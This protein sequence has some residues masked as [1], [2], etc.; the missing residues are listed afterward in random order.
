MNVRIS[1]NAPCPCGSGKKYKKCC[2]ANEAVSITS[3]LESEIDQLQRRMVEFALDYYNEEIED[4]FEEFQE[5]LMTDSQEELRFFEMVHSIWFTMF[6]PLE[7]GETILEKFILTAA[8][9]LKRPKLKQIL[10]SWIHPRVIIG[11]ITDTDENKVL[12]ED[13]F[14]LQEIEAIIPVMEKTFEK[15]TFII[16][17]LLPFDQQYAFIPAP[18]D[19]PS[20]E[21]EQAY[22]F[23]RKES[24]NAGYSSPQEYV[25]DFFMEVMYD[26]PTINGIVDVGEMDWPA[27]VYQEVAERFRKSLEA[28]GEEIPVIEIGI[29]LWYQFCQKKQKRIQNP[30]I[31]VGSLH[32]LITTIAPTKMNYTQK[33]IA[34]L[35]NASV[36]SISSIYGE[37]YDLLEDEIIKMID[38]EDSVI[39]PEQPSVVQFN[40]QKGPMGTERALQ[41]AMAELQGKNF[42]S[43]EEVNEFLNKKFLGSS[44]KKMPKGIKEQAMDLVYDAFEA[45]GSRRYQLAKEALGLDP[46][47]ADAY[48]ILAEKTKTLE[49]A[50]D[51]YEKAMKAAEEELGKSFIKE[52]KGHFWGLIETRP[53]MRAKFHYAQTLYRLGKMDD[54]VKQYQQL[55]DL[56]PND[57]QGVRESLFIA[58]M[59][60]GN[61]KSARELLEKYEE[62]TA[63]G[64]YNKVLLEIYEHGFTAQAEKLLAEAKKQNRYVIPF[65]REKKRIPKQ[66]PDYYGWGDE[67]EAVIYAAGHLELWKRI[68]GLEDWLK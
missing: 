1:R 62:E 35:Y 55:L 7:D 44:P 67:N 50:A 51:M 21:V 47:N 22:E 61:V 41:E 14:T 31:Y 12:A 68:E 19:L 63:Q 36:G 24:Q 66:L 58:Y 6:V 8:P 46:N 53:F 34:K 42:E 33:E 56:N 5:H 25:T 9:K 2:G 65:L 10:E 60:S 54:A 64:L 39:Q 23:I 48:V 13:G 28:L 3:M 11:K 37:I 40:H 29:L 45:T 30:D 16:G 32:Y 4:D 57:N 49:E 20:L 38:M 26:L 15:G 43:I 17:M 27:P 52:N 18:F 59:H